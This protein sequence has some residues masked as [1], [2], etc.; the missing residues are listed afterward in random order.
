[1]ENLPL[2]PPNLSV[3]AVQ[4]ASYPLVKAAVAAATTGNFEEAE[5]ALVSAKAAYSGLSPYC[6]VEIA[7]ADEFAGWRVQVEKAR[8]RWEADAPARRA[9]WE[10]AAPVRLPK[11]RG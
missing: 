7:Y 5:K 11:S 10:A 9:A 1:M 3:A 2:A 4:T 8:A 6:N